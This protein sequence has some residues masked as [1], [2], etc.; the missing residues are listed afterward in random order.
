MSRNRCTPRRQP[1]FTLLEVILALAI[2]AGAVAML[3]EAMSI[4]GRSAADAE[5][6]AQAQLLASTVM[7]EMLAGMVELTQQSNQPLET[8][9]AIPWVYS[10]TLGDTSLAGLMSVEVLVEQDV[11]KQFRPVKFRL[12]RWLPAD[13]EETE[14]DGEPTEPE[15]GSDA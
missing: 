8:N 13:L 10:V 12:L 6:E 15:E 1:G 7:D 4:A 2:L 14:E 5:A 11:E 9:S 3:G